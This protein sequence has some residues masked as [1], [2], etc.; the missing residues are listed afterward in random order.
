CFIVTR[1]RHTEPKPLIT[2]ILDIVVP[3]ILGC[4]V[5]MLVRYWTD[6]TD[7]IL[8]MT[9]NAD[10]KMTW[11]DMI[12]SGGIWL[13]LDHIK[14]V[15]CYGIPILISFAFVDRP[16]RF[17]LCVAAICMASY[18]NMSSKGILLRSRSFFGVL[19]VTQVPDEPAGLE[20]VYHKLVHGTT[21]HGM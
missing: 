14:S 6:L 18:M 19:Q 7:P 13:R 11:G 9:W 10:K 5:F 3:L 12:D 20:N 17:G 8:K 15:L 21:L 16:L 1:S 2:V 4:V